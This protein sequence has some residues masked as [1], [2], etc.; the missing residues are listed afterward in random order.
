MMYCTIQVGEFLK[1]IDA[2][3]FVLDCEYNMDRFSMEENEN[4]T[5]AFVQ[6]LRQSQPAAPIIISEVTYS[7]PHGMN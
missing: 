5:Y 6:Q 4:R 1:E 7:Q 2:A 3:A